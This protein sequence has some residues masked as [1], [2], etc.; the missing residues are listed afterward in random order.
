MNAQETRSDDLTAIKGIG[1]ARQQWFNE[2]LAVRTYEQLAAL[3]ADEIDAS[4]KTAGK[5]SSRAEIESWLGQARALVTT[6]PAVFQAQE[7]LRASTATIAPTSETWTPMASFVVEFQKQTGAAGSPAWRT[8]AHYVEADL[9]ATWPS[10]ALDQVRQW[11]A[12]HVA[13]PEPESEESPPEVE[14]IASPVQPPTVRPREIRILQRP[15]DLTTIDMARPLPPAIRHVSH[16]KPI[17]I[18]VDLALAGAANWPTGS[19]VQYTARCQVHDLTRGQRPYWLD[20]ETA[21]AAEDDT[22]GVERSEFAEL[23][24]E[25]G[26]YAVGILISGPQVAGPY[27]VELPKLNVL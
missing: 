8:V 17:T 18:E 4:L 21:Q 12:E 16:E 22:A 6:P 27:Y 7:G 25:P 23:Q 1:R 10:V 9:G 19:P 3:S 14:A 20:M 13:M 15:H 24:L 2:T 26:V 11:L 5:L